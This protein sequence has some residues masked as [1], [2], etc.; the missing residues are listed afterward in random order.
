M[1]N[2]VK[3]AKVNDFKDGVKKKVAAGGQEIML[4]RV[5]NNYYAISSRCP[6]MGGDLSIGK[7]EGTVI[8]CPRHG[9]QFDIKNGQNLRWMKGSGLTYSIGKT[10]KPP[11][12]V[13]TYPVKI[14]GEDITIEG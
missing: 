4:A 7:L 9:S 8:T 6:H 1:A 11:Q 5:G 2:Y 10:L 13:K 12:P 3:V 14:V